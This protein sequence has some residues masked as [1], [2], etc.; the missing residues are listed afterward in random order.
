ME[1]IYLEG[2]KQKEIDQILRTQVGW[3]WMKL[4]VTVIIK[5]NDI[6]LIY[7]HF[8]WATSFDEYTAVKVIYQWVINRTV[9]KC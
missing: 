8:I 7:L 9:W 6:L 5:V 1:K 2:S 4:W 3:P